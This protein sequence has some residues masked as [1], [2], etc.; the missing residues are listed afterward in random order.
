MSPQ[1]TANGKHLIAFG[2]AFV[3]FVPF[4]QATERALSKSQKECKKRRQGATNCVCGVCAAC[5]RV[6]SIFAVLSCSLPHWPLAESLAKSRFWKS[7]DR[8]VAST[9]YEILVN[10]PESHRYRQF[11]VKTVVGTTKQMHDSLLC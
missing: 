9:E 6:S 4:S 8:W 7:G 11:T 1:L 10:S 5:E 2:C 3:V